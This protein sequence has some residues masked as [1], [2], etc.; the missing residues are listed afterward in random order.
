MAVPVSSR[1]P[2]LACFRGWLE[3]VL[4]LSGGFGSSPWELDRL[5]RAWG[6]AW[7]DSLK[8]CR[9]YRGSGFR[10]PLCPLVGAVVARCL[11]HR[12]DRRV[13]LGCPRVS[14]LCAGMFYGRWREAE[15]VISGDSSACCLYARVVGVLP[16]RMHNRMVLEGDPFWV[17][18]YGDWLRTNPRVV[19]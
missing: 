5:F 15:G 9:W 14:A 6:W 19:R 3:S 8:V 18:V 16:G 7:E 12:L 4:A 2:E 1:S 10:D 17:G 13:V 11:G